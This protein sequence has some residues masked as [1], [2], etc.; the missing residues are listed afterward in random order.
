MKGRNRITKSWLLKKK[1][2]SKCE[3]DLKEEEK[4]NLLCEIV[5]NDNNSMLKWDV[6]L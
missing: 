6:V 1:S 2:K 3:V 4:A 5:Y